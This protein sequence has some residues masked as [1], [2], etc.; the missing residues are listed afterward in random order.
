MQLHEE[1]APLY[2]WIV[3]GSLTSSVATA[4]TVMFVIGLLLPDISDDLGLSPSEQGWLGSTVLLGNLIF[5]IPSNLWLSR[6][7][8]WRIASL[9]FLGV[10]SF[11]LLQGWS[12]IFAVLIIGR[13][14]VGISFI[15]SQAPRAL[16][17]QQW[18]PRHR[19]PFTQ[20]VV[21]GSI[22][23]LMGIAFFLTPL[24]MDWLDGWRNT[25]YLWSG[26][27]F[28]TAVVWMILGKER[29]TSEY[30]ERMQ[31][32]VE[33]PLLTILKYKQLWVMGLGMASAMLTQTAFH[34]FWPTFAR[35]DLGVS[36][37]MTG[38]VLGLMTI[39]AGPTDFLVNAVPALVRRQPLV[40]A[41]CGL[42]TTGTY[43]GLLYVDAT[44][45]VILLA[46][47]KGFFFAFF[48]V[49][50]IMVYQLPGIRPREVAVGVAFMQTSI[51]IG[52]AIGPLLVGF[53][54]EATG[55]L[56]FALLVTAFF[57]LVLVGS[58]VLL[59]TQRTKPTPRVAAPAAP[60]H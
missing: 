35:D 52:A 27:G 22:D 12:P 46:V 44:P 15:A 33:S 54:Q 2:R 39:V 21:F 50:M 26:L 4:L 60:G 28:L 41:L 47:M 31:S 38:V 34:T 1:H 16:I 55:D 57:P 14:G 19:L 8:P 51:W 53:L 32:Q 9:A 3:I 10:A 59:Q 17:I 25:M 36:A 45:L 23:I 43:T 18:T 29:V 48:P 42:V 13:V 56:Q 20:G 11:T 58:A 40:L 24:I 30:R 7:R 6:Y 5:A 37:T 49:L